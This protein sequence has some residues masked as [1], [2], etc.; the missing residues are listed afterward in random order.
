MPS[1]FCRPGGASLQTLPVAPGID[2]TEVLNRV[3]RLIKAGM[4]VSALS[5]ATTAGIQFNPATLKAWAK[6]RR[7]DALY[8]H[9]RTY[10]FLATS[11]ATRL[12]PEPVQP[13]PIR[14]PM[15]PPA[16]RRYRFVRV[17][18]KVAC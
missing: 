5:L 2:R 3:Q 17:P 14:T 15:M 9:R 8:R 16:A 6:D 12:E 1:K 10:A 7:R 11:L 4:C 13:V 18:S